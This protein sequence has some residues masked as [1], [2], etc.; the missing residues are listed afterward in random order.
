VVPTFSAIQAFLS[1][2]D[3]PVYEAT[4]QVTSLCLSVRYSNQGRKSSESLRAYFATHEIGP[5]AY[6]QSAASA[7]KEKVIIPGADHTFTSIA[8]ERE[9]IARTVHWFGRHLMKDGK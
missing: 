3:K 7:A 9:V 1:G 8:W 2:F 4:G 5:E 6:F